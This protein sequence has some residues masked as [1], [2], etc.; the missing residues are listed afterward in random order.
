MF[1]AGAAKQTLDIG[2]WTLD[3]FKDFRHWT[4]DIGLFQGL[5]TLDCFKDFRHWTVSRTLDSDCFADI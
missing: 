5:W 1:R 3:C 2:L 4:L